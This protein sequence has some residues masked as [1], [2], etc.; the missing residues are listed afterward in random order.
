[1]QLQH[2]RDAHEAQSEAQGAHPMDATDKPHLARALGALHRRIAGSGDFS[3]VVVQ[4][5]WRCHQPSSG[6]LSQVQRH[7]GPL[8]RRR[9]WQTT[10]AL[11]V[12]KHHDV[13]RPA[14]PACQAPVRYIQAEIWRKLF[15]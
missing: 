2:R 13:P 1:M 14:H 5:S 6:P 7:D 8:P 4:Q 3:Q 10:A 9:L 15:S 12:S 11:V